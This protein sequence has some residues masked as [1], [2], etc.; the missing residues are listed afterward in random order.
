ME[1]VTWFDAVA[2]VNA[3]SAREGLPA[4]YDMDVAFQGARQRAPSFDGG[5][6]GVRGARVDHDRVLE[7]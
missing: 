7:R 5:R 1:S 6:M 4:W 3:L 2:F